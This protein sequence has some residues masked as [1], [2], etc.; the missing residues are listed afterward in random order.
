MTKRSS[1]VSAGLDDLQKAVDMPVSLNPRSIGAMI[2]IS[3]LCAVLFMKL[4]QP[5]PV[6][7]AIVGAVFGAV[8]GVFHGRSVTLAS[9]VLR[10]AQS[11][12]EVHNALMST[13]PGRWANA[14]H[15]LS[16]F[17]V[18][19]VAIWTGSLLGVLAGLSAFEF[20]LNVL[21]VGPVVRF[22]RDLRAIPH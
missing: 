12:A 6:I 13:V 5:A 19:G 8:V 22:R 3:A 1:A 10:N 14:T 16:V 9:Q 4:A 18:L 17:A 2:A 7:P 20:T 11:S 15:W 21:S